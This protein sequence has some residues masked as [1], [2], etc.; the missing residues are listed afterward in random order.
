[1][2]FFRIMS[3]IF[4]LFNSSIKDPMLFWTASMVAN[5]LNWVFNLQ[6]GRIL[7]KED[8]AT[9]SVF[10]SLQ[11]LS[12]V[13][14]NALSTTISRFTA[15]Y[16][17]KRER[18][19]HFFFFRQYWWLAWCLGILL[20]TA[21][22]ILRES[23]Q[24]FFSIDS[25]NLILFFSFLLIPLFL[26]AFEKGTLSGQ[27]AFIWLGVLV[28][29][30]ALT[31]VLIIF[32]ADNLGIP[33]LNLAVL[34]LPVSIFVAW[35]V[36]LIV[37]RSYH[38][39]PAGKS[40]NEFK[41]HEVKETYNFLS[42]SFLAGLGVVLIYSLDVLLI[43]H[44][45]PP[46]EAGVFSTLSLLGKM[47]F[48]GAGSLIGLLIPLT[49]KDIAKNLSG[50]KPFLI[51][52]SV[53]SAIGLTIW[54]SYLMIPQTVVKILLTE[55]G[56]VALP[57]LTKY[58]LAMLFLVL[59]VCFST[60]NLAKKN[61]LPSRL[62]ILAAI[63][64]AGLIVLFHNSLHQVVDII[65]ITMGTLFAV[66]A[67]VDILKINLTSFSTNV[68][69]FVD[70]FLPITVP[71]NT[72]ESRK[73]L[74]FNWRDLKHIHSGG[75]EVYISELVSNLK[76]Y[77][78][79]ITLFTS[80]DGQNKSY[81]KINGTHIIRRG[82]FITVYLWA[83]IY[84]ILKFRRKYD[85]IIDCENGI[86][87]FTPL[88]VRRPV[89]LLIHH[90][91]QDV[92]F[93]SL[94]PPFSWMANFAESILMPLVYRKSNIVTIS[95]STAA[96]V[97]NELGLSVSKIIPSGVDIE[98]FLP[99]R[100]SIHPQIL[101]LGRL[102]KYKSI[103]VLLL[104]FEKISQEYP[105]ATL[106]IAGDGDY[107]SFLEYQSSHLGLKSKV[108]FLG[109]ISEERKKTLLAQSWVLVNP[110]FME[111]WGIT[112][113]EANACATPVIASNVSGLKD[114]VSEGKSGY[115]FEYGN[116]LELYQRIRELIL[117]KDKRLSL[118]K[119]SR[120]WSKKFSWSLQAKTFHLLIEEIFEKFSKSTNLNF[121]FYNLLKSYRKVD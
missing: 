71:K 87:F 105:K 92:F 10:L 15:F 57:Y 20:V 109:K 108:K 85:L 107:R 58:S 31:K 52:L 74:I 11:Y 32:F 24:T 1:M 94:I 91:H 23:I 97:S 12:T 67:L 37:T 99:M 62:I 55:R 43:K 96:E 22:I 13:P 63:F 120:V 104:A 89:I 41:S 18:E 93:K 113:I 114:A 40:N 90:I 47:L 117:N 116:H 82:G 83:F 84:Y 45:F 76:K 27:L 39:L 35:F 9:L 33:Y 16:S 19:K 64:E 102:K 44:Y 68:L 101:Y 26:L 49:A 73:I 30:E 28:I 7:T 106:I 61:Y 112:C 54:F 86:P 119:S 34:A 75:A 25:S 88:Y 111:G 115:L 29:V 81:E 8:F 53:V 48:F 5:V 50:R 6:A 103:E 98:S 42:N 77:G 69:S 65:L 14:A 59:A 56:Y 79:N 80:N 17:Q 46:N 60:Y 51:L 121:S 72:L 36:G 95:N 4:K 100:K 118:Y 78:Y 21:F 3:K 2:H 110:S 66:I 70:L 38:P